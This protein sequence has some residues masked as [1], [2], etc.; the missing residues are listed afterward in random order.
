MFRPVTAIVRFIQRLRRVLS[1]FTINFWCSHQSRTVQM[2][3][4]DFKVGHPVVFQINNYVTTV[5]TTK[6]VSV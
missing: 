3:L 1:Y 6:C 4:V 5:D 2:S